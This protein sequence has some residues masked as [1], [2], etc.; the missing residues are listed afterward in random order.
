MKSLKYWGEE[1][2][3][4]R[5]ALRALLFYQ[6][7]LYNPFMY[8]KI[9]WMNRAQNLNPFNSSFFYWIDAGIHIYPNLFP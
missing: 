7:P 9:V 6:V 5:D 2:A 3:D 8:S 4:E 1:R